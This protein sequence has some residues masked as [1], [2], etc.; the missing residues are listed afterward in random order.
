MCVE[1]SL[2]LFRALD[3]RPGV[4]A[5]CLEIL[6]VL[7]SLEGDYA[8][9]C[10]YG[11]EIVEAH[12][13]LGDDQSVAIASGNLAR[14]LW[15]AGDNGR[16][17]TL[18]TES[19][20]LFTALDNTWAVASS[21]VNLG[22]VLRRLDDIEQARA[23]YTRALTMFRDTEHAHGIATALMGLAAVAVARGRGARSAWLQG[24]AEALTTA[25]E[26]SLIPAERDEIAR[27]EAH[28]RALAGDTEYGAARVA[29]RA[30]PLDDMI[31][32]ALEDA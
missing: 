1:E 30:A 16:A 10:A 29:G 17:R 6:R 21:L 9:A 13:A 3:D 7:A 23:S 15:C 19:L 31:A 26:H 20:G 11:E 22:D 5:H 27:V 32:Y 8:R 28:A 2:A 18:L 25:T 4:A 24:A 14:M 12:R